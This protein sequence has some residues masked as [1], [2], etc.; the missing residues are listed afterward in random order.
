VKIY[1][2]RP[3][4]H[5]RD[6]HLVVVAWL[7]LLELQAKKIAGVDPNDILMHFTS[8]L[9]E[10]TDEAVV[11]TENIFFTLRSAPH[12]NKTFAKLLVSGLLAPRPAAI[13]LARVWHTGDTSAL[14]GIAVPLFR[15]A[16]DAAGVVLMDRG[17]PLYAALPDSFTVYRGSRNRPTDEAGSSWTLSV[18][19]ARIF[20]S[21]GM[22]DDP[23]RILAAEIDKADALAVFNVMGE[24]EIVVDSSGLRNV[25]TIEDGIARTG[26]SALGEFLKLKDTENA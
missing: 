14:D 19:T 2:A 8:T 5:F 23:G 13:L 9:G 17:W 26:R 21:V 6:E 11:A 4:P 24:R 3:K 15:A 22:G 7:R 18:D 20:A 12:S 16:R 10:N 25:R 1:P